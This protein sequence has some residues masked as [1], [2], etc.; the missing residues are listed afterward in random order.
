[1]GIATIIGRIEL[2]YKAIPT[3]AMSADEAVKLILIIQLC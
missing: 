1:M 3:K 2:D